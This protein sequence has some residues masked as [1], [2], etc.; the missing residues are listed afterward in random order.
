MLTGFMYALGFPGNV[1]LLFALY[2]EV[3]EVW[4]FLPVGVRA[5]NMPQPGFNFR[6]VKTF[7]GNGCSSVLEHVHCRQQVPGSQSS[8]SPF[9]RFSSG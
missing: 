4:V 2:E 1:L 3:V 6:S 8:A 5:R 9:K 7:L